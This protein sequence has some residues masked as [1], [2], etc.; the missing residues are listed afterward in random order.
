[1]EDENI[2]AGQQDII[3]TTPQMVKPVSPYMPRMAE[4]G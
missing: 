3:Y 2:K 4:Y 1:M